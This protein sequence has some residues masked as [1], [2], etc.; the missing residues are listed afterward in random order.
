MTAIILTLLK[1]F[2][3]HLALAALLAGA[4]WAAYNWA[5]A[6]GATA[7]NQAC[8]TATDALKRA[9]ATALATEQAKTRALERGLQAFTDA[10]NT[11][12]HQN[13]QTVT[14]LADRL[15]R[16]ADSAGRLRDPNAPGC[17]GRSDSPAP[18]NASAASAGA[19]DA[20]LPGG[21]LSAELS[22]LLFER[23]Q[24]ADQINAAYAS[25]R[26]VAVKLTTAP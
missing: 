5:H 25:C 14:A 24:Q 22:G 1:K 13:A 10:Q 19:T 26:A 4:C 18:T 21:L 12:D 17:G 23:L 15:R 7:A 16:T 8:T 6:R 11:K 2:G 3:G 9:A 20:T